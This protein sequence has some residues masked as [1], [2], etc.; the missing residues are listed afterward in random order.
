[1]KPVSKEIGFKHPKLNLFSFD[2]DLTK[3][4][5]FWE[6]FECSIHKTK[7]LCNI[8]TLTCL[9]GQLRGKAAKLVSGFKLESSSYG[10]AVQ[11]LHDNYGR[12]DRIS[13]ALVTELV[14]LPKLHH[15]ISSLKQFMAKYE[16]LYTS[17]DAQKIGRDEICTILLLNYLPAPVKG[18]AKIKGRNTKY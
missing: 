1:M 15:N 6:M 5:K 3:W 13:D 18:N 9:K 14:D 10:S 2:G 17:L 16:G 11:L 4:V 7:N 12:M 8:Q